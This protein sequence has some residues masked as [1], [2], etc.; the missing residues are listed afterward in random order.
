MPEFF[1]YTQ[2]PFDCLTRAERNRL[3]AASDIEYFPA[4]STPIAAGTAVDALYVIIKGVV[5]EIEDGDIVASYREHDCF[6]GRALVGGTAVRAFAVHDDAI[7]HRIPR[8]LVLALTRSNPLFG[9]WFYQDVAQRLAAL[10]QHAMQG[11][12]QSLITARVADAPLRAPVWL[13]G[14]ACVLDAA[15]AMKDAR[16]SS[17][18][19][20]GVRGDGLFT[21][22]DLRDLVIAGAD[23]ATTTLADVAQYTLLTIADGAHVAEALLAFTRHRVQRLPVTRDGGIVGVLEQIDLLAYFSNHSYLVAAQIERASD[24]DALAAAAA[25]LRT[26]IG[27][28]HAQGVRIRLIASLVSELTGQLQQKL[29]ELVFPPESRAH[30]CILALG[31]QGRG[32]QIVPTDQ[33]NALIVA[34]GYAGPPL[35]DAAAA[36]NA[37]LAG[38]GY[39]RCPGGVMLCNPHWRQRQADFARRLDAQIATPDGAAMLELAMWLDA[40]PVAGNAALWPPLHQRIV[41]ASRGNDAMLSALALPIVQFAA[42]ASLFS[43]L[44]GS[45]EHVDLKKAGLFPIVHGLRVLALQAG[46]NATNSQ[47]RIDALVDAHV[48]APAFGRDLSE[49]LSF[50]QALQLRL[51]LAQLA[52]GEAPSYRLQPAALAAIERELLKDALGIARRLRQLVQHR[53]SLQHF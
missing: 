29:F 44:T 17:V 40:A 21:Q 32:E 31:S 4:G 13:A 8:D 33:D 10:A 2:P 24:V 53:F 6:D 41:A 11:E 49:A 26:L 27:L 43:R 37:A 19:V 1:S 18:L 36:Y 45:D 35:D 15:R 52:R 23:A 20:R 48:L 46:I 7:V 38:F 5:D 22:S 12:L 28:L 16:T 30:A 25:Q 9:A 51:G 14:D 34:D 50:L 42:P 47:R 3:E 39:P